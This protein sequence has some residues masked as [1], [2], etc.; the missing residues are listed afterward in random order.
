MEVEEHAAA[1]RQVSLYACGHV[2][3]LSRRVV[4]GKPR[5]SLGSIMY[6]FWS[7]GYVV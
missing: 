4:M 5:V 7:I 3:L 2:S 6:L 1:R